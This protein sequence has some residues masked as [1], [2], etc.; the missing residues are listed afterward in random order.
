MDLPDEFW[1]LVAVGRTAFGQFVKGRSS[2]H[3]ARERRAEFQRLETIEAIKRIET[4]RDSLQ[5]S[6]S[7]SASA[8]PTSSPQ[9]RVRI[10]ASSINAVGFKEEV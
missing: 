8:P 1:D 6:L 9:T 10:L 7:S 3:V 2:S 5:A 4:I